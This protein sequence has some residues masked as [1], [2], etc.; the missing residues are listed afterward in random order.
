MKPEQ[1]RLKTVLVD[2]VTLLCKNGLHFERQLKVQGLIGVTIDENDVFIIHINETIGDASS[3][4]SLSTACSSSYA[5]QP[6]AGLRQPPQAPPQKRPFN[7]AAKAEMRK[8]PQLAAKRFRN[9]ASAKLAKLPPASELARQKARQQLKF[10]SPPRVTGQQHRLVGGSNTSS[11]PGFVQTSMA[12]T[13]MQPRIPCGGSA[14]M[15]NSP[16]I[17]AP[18]NPPHIPQ[19]QSA[20]LSGGSPSS[21]VGNFSG[22]Y[23]G[24]LSPFEPAAS[25]LADSSQHLKTESYNDSDIIFVEDDIPD[26]S[27]DDLQGGSFPT[28][29]MDAGFETI[30]DG[31]EIYDDKS[32]I[33]GNGVMQQT[34]IT[35]LTITTNIQGQNV[36]KY[37]KL[38]RAT[39][40]LPI[41]PSV[42]MEAG[43][44]PY[45]KAD[46]NMAST[47]PGMDP[48]QTE[49]YSYGYNDS[50]MDTK[51]GPSDYGPDSSW[52]SGQDIKSSPQIYSVSDI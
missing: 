3:R 13:K 23:E 20:Q 45:I 40:T 34:Q 35:R 9:L 16:R 26:D 33:V 6:A 48:Y 52:S 29:N 10:A 8:T 17:T 15:L 12:T 30:R 21:S 42:K 24:Y 37:E 7:V 36:Q 5:E 46:T 47:N 32:G 44:Q 11:Q 28:T 14:L 43:C 22:E 51:L 2:T 4:T 38:H 49:S 50:Q 18:F 31:Q 39:S 19:S 25:N 27:R 41:D 1:E